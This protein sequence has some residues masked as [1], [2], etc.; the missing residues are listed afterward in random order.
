MLKNTEINGAN[1]YF[2]MY[3]LAK[4][5]GCDEIADAIYK[6]AVEDAAHGGIN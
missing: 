5:L 4:E 2:T 6:N 1:Q 3:F